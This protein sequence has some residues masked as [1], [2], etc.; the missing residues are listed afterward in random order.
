MLNLFI[1]CFAFFACLEKK[2][3]FKIIIS[4]YIYVDIKSAVFLDKPFSQAPI[5]SLQYK[6][7]EE[8]T[9]ECWPK[10]SNWCIL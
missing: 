8:R 7:L 9:I 6:H 2:K 4:T 5:K 3:L 10:T 1:H